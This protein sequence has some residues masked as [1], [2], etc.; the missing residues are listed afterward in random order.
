MS[1]KNTIVLVGFS[2][3]TILTTLFFSQVSK[4]QK[5]LKI[6]RYKLNYTAHPKRSYFLRNA[7]FDYN[8]NR[9]PVAQYRLDKN[10]ARIRQWIKKRKYYEK[11][12][13]KKIKQKRVAAQKWFFPV[14]NTNGSVTIKNNYRPGNMA[15]EAIDIFA[16]H[17]SPVYAPLT[18]YVVYAGDN[19]HGTYKKD[20]L[21]YL[22]GGLTPK[23]GNGLLLYTP[24]TGYFWFAHMKRGLLVETGDVVKR[25]EKLGYLSNTGNAK[26][27]GHGRHLHLAY[28]KQG[29]EGRYQNVLK[30][31]NPYSDLKKAYQR[32]NNQSP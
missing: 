21:E 25:G 5:K 24:G 20:G 11:K 8:F 3:I 26:Q 7:F 31:A 4:G 28:K 16:P 19:W 1:N 29:T 15:H 27:K 6:K 23:A 14:R 18:S 32:Y 17:G 12:W 10:P 2:V 22:G 9:H 30:A 13:A